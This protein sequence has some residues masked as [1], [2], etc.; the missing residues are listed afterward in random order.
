MKIRVTLLIDFNART[1][2]E[3]NGLD[4]EPGAENAVVRADVRQAVLTMMQA[5]ELLGEA[6]AT[7]S[8]VEDGRAR[9]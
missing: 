3:N 4:A 5:S 7:V 8:L 1:W 2:V 6:D 9:A